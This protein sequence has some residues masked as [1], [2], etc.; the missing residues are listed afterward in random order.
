MKKSS[1]SFVLP[2]AALFASGLTLTR[3]SAGLL[4]AAV[5]AETGAQLTNASKP[6]SSLALLFTD[7]DVFKPSR[8]LLGGSLMPLDPFLF[9]TFSAF[10][11]VPAG[12]E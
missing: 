12:L 6:S 11:T 7:A 10:I 9:R 2:P 4:P 3:S 1:S 5:A 8:S